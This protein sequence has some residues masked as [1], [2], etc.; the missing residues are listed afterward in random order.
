MS[1]ENPLGSASQIAWGPEN[2]RG[3]PDL[4]KLYGIQV[5]KTTGQPD[6]KSEKTSN[7]NS[8]GTIL[9]EEMV[10][11]D[12][13]RTLDKQPD[14][15]SIVRLLTHFHG[16][17]AITNPTAGVY[18]WVIRQLLSG[19]AALTHVMDTIYMREY[20]DDDYETLFTGGKIDKLSWKIDR[21][22]I[23]DLAM[24]ALFSHYSR[25]GDPSVLA[26]N[27]TYTGQLVTRG[28]TADETAAAGVIIKLTVAGALDGTAQA[29]CSTEAVAYGG[30][31][32]RI[33]IV[34][35]VWNKVLLA[36]GSYMAAH[37]PDDVMEFMFTAGGTMTLNAEYLIERSHAKSTVTYAQKNPL[38]AVGCSLFLAGAEV[39]VE[40]VTIE[41]R[42]PREAY[43]TVGHASARRVLNNG[44]REPAM[45]KIPKRYLDRVALRQLEKRTKIA[46]KAALRGA[47]IGATA[48]Y[49]SIDIEAPNCHVTKAGVDGIQG[50]N[51]F[52]EDVELFAY[53]DPATGATPMVTTVVG[54]V[55]TLV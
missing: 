53:Y 44:E 25:A 12:L 24:T 4:T 26:A 16:W 14:V 2:S 8:F 39:E 18:Q 21:N 48:Y 49:E 47:Q 41:Q 19:D 35:G 46:F 37:Y 15:D 13:A 5:A 7:I 34:A 20:L 38:T 27:G 42:R 43:F 10:K 45:I 28:G 17:A 31:T 11:I 1:D 32:R 22:K 51:S 36:D 23:T 6:R 55:A 3:V 40:G 52:K 29:E 54:T 33:P 30:V 9:D 50:P